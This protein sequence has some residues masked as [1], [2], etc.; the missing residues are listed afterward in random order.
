MSG[1]SADAIDVALV[2]IEGE[3]IQLIDFITQPN[4]YQATLATLNH[5]P[6]ISLRQLAEFQVQIAQDFALAANT[7]IAKHQLD[8]KDIRAIGSHGQTLFHAPDIG[9]SI[10]A[11]HPAIIAKQ[12]GITTAADFRIDDMALGGQGAPLAPAFHQA[13]LRPTSPTL[14]INI[15]GIANISYL[16]P[17]KP[18][19]GFDS[20]PGNGLMDELCQSEFNRPYDANGELAK[21]TAPDSAIL[22][23]LLTER[24]FQQP[25]PKST[26]RET[27]NQV[28]L[29]KQ[30]KAVI[31]TKITPLTL[32]STLNQLTV[33]ALANDID[34]LDCPDQTVCYICGGGAYNLTLL[35]R[36]QARLPQLRI[37]TTQQLG[38]DP[39]AIEAMMCAWL[40]HNRI[41]EIETPLA[42]ITG[43]QKNTVLGGVWLA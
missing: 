38:I 13:L 30:L 26:G 36:L 32:L 17:S 8:R 29:Q 43:A 10:Q 14:L 35:E 31:K 19:L 22:E 15:G 5:Q 27:F 25:P 6:S 21:Q 20:G 3:A 18:P 7:M 28:W 42:A 37:Q 4:H 2:N 16:Q 39:N 33:D 41:H 24:Y 34:K 9:M 23:H 40:A 1:T 12:S 11:G